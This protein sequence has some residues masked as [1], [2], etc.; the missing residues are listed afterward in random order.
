MFILNQDQEQKHSIFGEI[1]I[2]ITIGSE[3]L[4][5]T[6]DELKDTIAC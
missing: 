4:S 6:I 1:A 2:I 5:Q 3:K